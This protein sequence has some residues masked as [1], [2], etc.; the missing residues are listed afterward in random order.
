MKLKNIESAD[1]APV[2]AEVAA[3]QPVAAGGGGKVATMIA[4]F[5]SLAAAAMVSAIVAMMYVNWE[6]IAN[7]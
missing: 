2:G 7:A 3:L 1:A 4:F 5:A 6:L